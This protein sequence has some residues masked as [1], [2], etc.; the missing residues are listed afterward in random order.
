MERR[1]GPFSRSLT[2][3]CNVSEDEVAA[4]CEQG[5]LTVALPKC[6]EARTKKV[7]VKG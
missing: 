5:V 2:L 1:S 4:E 6:E 3:P 7:S